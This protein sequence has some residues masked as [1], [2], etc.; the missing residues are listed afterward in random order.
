M[1][2]C[3]KIQECV[4]VCDKG[5]ALCLLLLLLWEN[6][7][8]HQVQTP[9]SREVSGAA[10]SSCWTAAPTLKERLCLDNQPARG[11]PPLQLSGR[12]GSCW[13]L[14]VAL[15]ADWQ[16]R[17]SEPPVESSLNSQSSLQQL[18][19]VASSAFLL[20]HSDMLFP[21]LGSAASPRRVQTEE[22]TWTG[23]SPNTHL[24]AGNIIQ[25]KHGCVDRD[26]FRTV[27]TLLQPSHKQACLW[28]TASMR[29]ATETNN[30]K[31][32]TFLQHLADF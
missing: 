17:L 8:S 15:Q 1:G 7:E 24:S 25:R 10:Y 21:K 19:S 12:A 30:R 16:T 18:A 13:C 29:C 20:H 14:V 11:S 4:F 27:S 22:A 23:I 9:A 31:S 2:L 32:S 26:K 3:V 6:P 5:G 28:C